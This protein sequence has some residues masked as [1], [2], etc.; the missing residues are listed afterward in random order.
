M[1][2]K[3]VALIVLA[4]SLA[5]SGCTHFKLPGGGSYTSFFN[6]KT[7]S[8]MKIESKSGDTNTLITVE[9]YRSTQAENLN[10]V[11]EGLGNA[12]INGMKGSVKPLP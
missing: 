3:T 5:V 10:A 4:A 7:I 9:G 8:K 2:S 6:S 1:K 11:S 12:I